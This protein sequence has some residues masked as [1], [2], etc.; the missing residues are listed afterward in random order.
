MTRT[1]DPPTL[2]DNDAPAPAP[3]SKRL[4]EELPLFCE[5][6]G[7]NLNG[8]PQARCEQCDILQFHCPECGHHQPIN[9]LRPAFQLLLARIRATWLAGMVFFK[10]NLLFWPLF[11]WVGM[12]AEWSY[13]Y[14]GSAS[15]RRFEPADPSFEMLT[16][17][18]VFGIIYGAVAR[19]ALL[20]WRRGY[21]VGL[22]MAAL[23]FA[24][25]ALGARM[26]QWDYDAEWDSP[27]TPQFVSVMIWGAAWVMLGASIIWPIWVML[28]HAFLPRR[29]GRALLEWQRSAS[30]RVSA[31]ARE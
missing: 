14:A 5:K 22:V 4:G 21:L 26:A 19:M 11:G 27:F 20:R 12:G 24:A 25:V 13:R 28:V 9:T 3:S 15:G 8:L 1:S 6:C 29:A 7:Y 10:L 31:L 2:R 18:A 17:F 30:Q 23:V 16:A